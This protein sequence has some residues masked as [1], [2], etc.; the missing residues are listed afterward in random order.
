[1]S[2]E[3]HHKLSINSL[4]RPSCISSCV[5]LWIRD[6][7]NWLEWNWYGLD[8][9]QLQADKAEVKGLTFMS[10]SW[11]LSLRLPNSCCAALN[12][13]EHSAWSKNIHC[14]VTN[15]RQYCSKMSLQSSV[16]QCIGGKNKGALNQKPRRFTLALC[17]EKNLWRKLWGSL[18]SLVLWQIV[19]QSWFLPTQSYW[20]HP[21]QSSWKKTQNTRAKQFLPRK[22]ESLEPFQSLR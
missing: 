16:S 18:M 21:I 15:F 20:M 2:S 22:G 9:I 11:D 5:V 4:C 6:N 14:S 10:E 8:W 1:M 13:A 17:R 12:N 19:I 7:W 3:F